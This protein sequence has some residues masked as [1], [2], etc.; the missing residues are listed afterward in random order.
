MEKTYPQTIYP[1]RDLSHLGLRQ[2]SWNK[3]G[4]SETYF[5]FILKKYFKEYLLSG[6][7]VD[8]GRSSPY[9]PDFIISIP[10]KN[11]CLD[12][13]IDEPYAYHS[14]KPI[15]YND[16]QRNAYFTN[17]GWTV[18]RFAEIQAIRT[19]RLCCQHICE[20]LRH[21]TGDYYWVEGFL[22]NLDEQDFDMPAW[23]KVDAMQLADQN[24]R[25]IY[26]GD[27]EEIHTIKPEVSVLIDGIF[28]SQELRS[29]L[30]FYQ[31]IY[32]EREFDEQ[33]G[34]SK[35]ATH[36][37]GLLNNIHPIPPDSPSKTIVELVVF[38]SEYHGLDK[39]ALDQ[40]FI[41]TEDFLINVF[42]SR[43]ARMIWAQIEDHVA[44]EMPSEIIL[45]ADDLAY[46]PT[47]EHWIEQEKEVILIKRHG[48]SNM[49]PR[50]RHTPVNYVIGMAYG[51]EMKE[52]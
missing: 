36:L 35:L 34:I 11:I 12:I 26:T 47:V 48:D 29:T 6:H 19:P 44:K 33:L 31:G 2:F 20:V 28:L 43:T 38:V 50:V 15:H 18:I 27:M 46:V 22:A 42:F 14:K 8:D 45:I 24:F 3:Q 10:E 51:L 40:D 16:Q 37:N 52:L 23:S 49:P 13:E 5:S 30:I 17:L 7:V 9:E 25:N 41:E 1:D 32:P 21:I 4:Y 39:F